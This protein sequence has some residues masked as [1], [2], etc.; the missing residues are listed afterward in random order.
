MNQALYGS[1][2][3]VLLTVS[4]IAVWKAVMIHRQAEGEVWQVI[5]DTINPKRFSSDAGNE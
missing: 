4:E 1:I 5:P 2:R 3:T